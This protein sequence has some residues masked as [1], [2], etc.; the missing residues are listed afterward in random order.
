MISG[1]L[2]IIDL[3]KMKI[4]DTGEEYIYK[5]KS[6]EEKHFD[7]GSI[8]IRMGAFLKNTN[9]H[10]LYF[11]AAR[12]H[13]RSLD[14]KMA[15]SLIEGVIRS[16]LKPPFLKETDKKYEILYE[17]DAIA[18]REILTEVVK[19]ETLMG[20]LIDGYEVIRDKNISYEFEKILLNEPV[21]EKLINKLL[22]LGKLSYSGIYVN[23]RIIR[24]IELGSLGQIISMEVENLL[25]RKNPQIQYKRCIQCGYVFLTR[26]KAGN[27]PQL[28]N[29][30]YS[31]GCCKKMRQRVVDENRNPYKAIDRKIFD[32]MRQKADNNMGRN[33]DIKSTDKYAWRDEYLKEMEPLQNKI[34]VVDYEKK[35]REKWK[36]ILNRINGK[37]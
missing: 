16:T 9:I 31:S 17:K 6:G 29:Y 18:Q 10:S 33:T 3:W 15:S 21:D 23:N 2:F 25:T 7:Y 4:T 1:E 13:P 32:S 22:S 14:D 12:K 5:T 24:E 20:G 30:N 19:Q 37:C 8:L 26:R 34:D 27:Q 11:G 28:C 35:A 36:L